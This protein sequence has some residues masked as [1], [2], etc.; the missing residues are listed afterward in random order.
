MPRAK[1][2]ANPDI[3]PS[4]TSHLFVSKKGGERSD[5]GALLTSARI[6]EDLAKFHSAGGRIEVL[7]NTRM[8]TRI[9]AD[10]DADAPAP[11]PDAT[12]PR[13]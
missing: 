6:A 11:R 4:N 9:D 1:T 3:P 10:A 12:T 5:R 7:G 13:R 8:L 2:P